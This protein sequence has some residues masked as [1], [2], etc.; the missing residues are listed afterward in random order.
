MKYLRIQFKTCALQSLPATKVT[1][2][3][4]NEGVRCASNIFYKNAAKFLPFN[5]K[6]GINLTYFDSTDKEN[7]GHSQFVLVTYLY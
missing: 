6:H 2:G 4:L 7:N 3:S 5:N 1:I